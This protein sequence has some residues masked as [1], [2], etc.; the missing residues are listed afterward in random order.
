MFYGSFFAI[1]GLLYSEI[2][3]SEYE[4]E[5]LL[6]PFTI[7]PALS[8]LSLAWLALAVGYIFFLALQCFSKNRALWRTNGWSS[9]L[10]FVVLLLIL[11]FFVLE[12]VWPEKSRSLMLMTFLA[13]T[14]NIICLCTQ[15]LF[16]VL[17]NEGGEE[18]KFTK[19]SEEQLSAGDSVD[20]EMEDMNWR[21]DGLYEWR[22][23]GDGWWLF[24]YFVL[25]DFRI[26]L[27]F[28]FVNVLGKGSRHL[29]RYYGDRQARQWVQL[30]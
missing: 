27:K 16:I 11:Y 28:N 24:E 29:G 21:M 30:L 20:I 3:I 2:A 18:F 22:M 5:V 9:F 1:I 26:L 17:P 4:S 7:S 6:Y 14:I 25:N 15:I 13:F 23:N 12:I 19:L 8:I 10:V